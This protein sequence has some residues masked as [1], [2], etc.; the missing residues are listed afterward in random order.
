MTGIRSWRSV[1]VAVIGASQLARKGPQEMVKSL[2]MMGAPRLP[3]KFGKLGS[4][5][6]RPGVVLLDALLLHICL[7]LARH[8]VHHQR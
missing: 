7:P 5:R 4:M 3:G 8:D 2:L 6:I 1:I